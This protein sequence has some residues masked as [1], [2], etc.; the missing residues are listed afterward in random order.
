M[1]I[2]VRGLAALRPGEWLSEPGNRNEGALRAKGGPHGARFYFRYRDSVGRYDDLPLGS[3]D[4]NGKSGMT[5]DKAKREARKLSDRYLRGDRDLRVVLDTERRQ[6]ELER[7]AA[8]KAQEVA[9]ARQAATLGALLGAYVRQLER[10]GKASAPAVAAAIKRHVEQPW[11]KLWATPADDVG[12]DDL[13]AVVAKVTDDGK[14]TE[15]R[16]LRAYLLAA[17]QAAIRA[18]QDARGLAAL[19]E[20]RVTTNPARDLAAIDG[21]SNARDRALSVAE[22]RAYWKR[23]EAMP[24]PKGALLRFHLLTGAQ[25]VEQ[26]A[27]LKTDDHDADTQ[28]VRLRDAKGRRK[29]A[30]VHDVP[31]IPEAAD[32][33]QAMAPERLGPYLFTVTAG[34]SGAVYA[35]VQHRIREVASAMAEA[36]ELE[37]GLFTPG[38]LRRTVETRLAAEGV[39]IDARAQLQSHGL[40]GVQARHYDRHDYLAEKLEALKTLHRLITGLSAKVSPIKRKAK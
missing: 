22:L 32:A 13:L 28:R 8:I 33:L 40:G 16:K 6:A 14:L 5:L 24:G 23:I 26:L 7:A 29:V 9:E 34:E 10:D 12:M 3:H 35:T 4:A 31:L 38:D 21:G 15:A 2:T 37:K 36:G 39:G 17:Y 20:L 27:R 19:R 25:R 1:G 18:R 11:P 30:R